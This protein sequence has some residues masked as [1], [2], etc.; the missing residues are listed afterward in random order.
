MAKVPQHFSGKKFMA[1][2][3]I[4]DPHSFR[5]DDDLVCPTFP[6]LTDADLLDCVETQAERDAMISSASR[7][8]VAKTEAALAVALKSLTPTQAVAYIDTNISNIASTKVVLKVMTRM[9]IAMRDQMWPE[10][11]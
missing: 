2:F 3:G 5:I 1:K 6:N 8:A 11:L 4:T 10:G 9:L 7:K